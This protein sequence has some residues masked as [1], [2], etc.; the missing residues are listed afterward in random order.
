[1]GKGNFEGDRQDTSYNQCCG[2]SKPYGK[3]HKDGVIEQW[4]EKNTGSVS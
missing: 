4:H 2:K 1:M 3:L